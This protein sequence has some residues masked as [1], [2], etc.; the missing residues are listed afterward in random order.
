MIITIGGDVCVTDANRE[1]FANKETKKLF[2]DIT[3]VYAQADYNIVNLECAIT[4]SNH[5]IMK[6]GPNL[7]GPL[8]TAAVLKE[9]GITHCGLSNNHTFDFGIP[10]FLDTMKSLDECGITYTG[11]GENNTDAR[12]DLIIEKDGIKIALIAVCEHEYSYALPDRMGAREYD[13][14]DT[15]DDIAK[16]KE[17]ADY[18]IVM[19]HGGKELCRYPS[20]R[21]RKLCRSMATHGADI[22]L[23]Q[24]SH[25]I[26]CY[27]NFKDCHIVYGQGNFHFA[28]L[29]GFNS[30]M[31]D[32]GLLLKFD[33]TKDKC[34]IEILPTVATDG[35][36]SLAKGETK[37]RLLKEL[38]DRNA[39]L[40]DG[41]WLE[42]WHEFC[43]DNRPNY[44]ATL[45]NRDYNHFSHY[46]DCE[47]HT[48]VWREL[49]PTWNK[50]N[51][52]DRK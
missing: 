42:G 9:A 13:P 2:S 10:G 37:E 33:I 17:N 46:L 45:A 47:A 39:E 40:Q 14:Y 4:E 24:H 30:D 11:T 20:P 18:V 5:K 38:E 23:C 16:A 6:Y 41:R 7:K 22:V 26:G 35:C 8:N 32:T 1:M 51:E 27:E 50:F 15:N 3:D 43:E 12:R 21:L 49:F 29:E 31:W 28:K 48:D 34:D 52:K 36:I 19:Y 44:T 25:C